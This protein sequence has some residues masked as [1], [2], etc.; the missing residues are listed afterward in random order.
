MVFDPDEIRDTATYEDPN[1]LSVGMQ[2]VMV[3]GVLVI[4]DGKMTGALPGRVIY[5]PGFAGNQESAP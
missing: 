3:N 4:D 2:Y 1:H 5:G